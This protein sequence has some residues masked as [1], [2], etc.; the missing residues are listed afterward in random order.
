MVI[1]ASCCL[2]NSFQ[3]VIAVQDTS[4]KGLSVNFSIYAQTRKDLAR[5]TT[6]FKAPIVRGVISYLA[7]K[8]GKPANVNTVPRLASSLGCEVHALA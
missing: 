6:C 5:I 7:I 4:R 3:L 1:L 2:K 8:T